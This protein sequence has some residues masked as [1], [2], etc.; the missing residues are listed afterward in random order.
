MKKVIVFVAFMLLLSSC[1]KVDLVHMENDISS[2]VDS[3][4]SEILE[5]SSLVDVSSD[6]PELKYQDFSSKIEVETVKT[7]GNLKI[8]KDRLRFSGSGYVTGFSDKSKLSVLFDLPQSQFYNISVTAAGSSDCSGFIT[9]NGQR[10]SLLKCVSD[11]EFKIYTFKNVYIA[12]GNATI[13]IESDNAGMCI[14]NI[15]LSASKDIFN[16]EFKYSKEL[17]NTNVDEKT[18]K[19]YNYLCENYGSKIITGQYVTVGSNNELELIKNTTNRYPAIRFSD[20]AYSTV[21]EDLNARD[22]DKAMQW[23]NKGGLVAYSWTWFAPMENSSWYQKDTDFKL[24]NAV[25]SDDVSSLS[26][27]EIK[28]LCNN[29]AISQECFEIL[30]DIDKIADDISRFKKENITVLFRPLPE[31]SGGWYWWGQ[32]K[33]DYLWLYDLI[34]DRLTYYHNLNNIIWIWNAQNPSWYVGDDKCDIISADIYT[35]NQVLDS[36][37]NI[38]LKLKQVSNSKMVAL[39]ECGRVPYMDCNIRD[40]AIW[41]FFGLFNNKYISDKTG[42]ISFEFSNKDELIKTYNH[43][44]TITLERLPVF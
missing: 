9:V 8:S 35:D 33:D 27:D 13:G 34:F 29:K 41:S 10:V 39:S 36:G 23:D 14:D 25:T 19:I 30:N 38:M 12:A 31:A 16:T 43:E 22:I 44:K 37:V 21:N 20:L 11:K 6:I 32:S 28:E 17:C 26:Q 1:A 2:Q 15:E 40:K 7:E 5:E 42:N 18:K 4:T 3:N 24:S